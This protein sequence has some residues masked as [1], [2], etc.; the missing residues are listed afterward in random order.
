MWI[1]Y[2]LFPFFVG[3]RSRIVEGDSDLCQET[4]LFCREMSGRALGSPCIAGPPVAVAGLDACVFVAA[5]QL[6]A[7][8]H[9][10]Y[11]GSLVCLGPVEIA[12]A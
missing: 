8:L 9:L 11:L 4:T 6:F 3:C 2:R 10:R 12:A 1:D 5:L 7:I